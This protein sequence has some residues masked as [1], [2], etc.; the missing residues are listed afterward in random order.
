MDVQVLGQDTLKIKI[1]KAGVAVNPKSSIQ[2]FD[3]DVI[4]INRDNCDVKRVNNYR[5]VIDGAG[6][7]EVSGLRVRGIRVGEGLIYELSSENAVILVANATA[8]E[9]V[10]SE[11]LDECRIAIINANGNL[12]ASLITALEPR[13]VILY[14]EKAKE[15]AKE[16][17]RENVSALS[18]ISFS[19]DKLPEEMEVMLLK[20]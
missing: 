8:L 15:S 11:R 14:G 12:N 3:A 10:S 20:P 16:F 5:V 17:G 7:F 6:D 18:K 4:L 13:V 2:K 19:E 9:N 1:K